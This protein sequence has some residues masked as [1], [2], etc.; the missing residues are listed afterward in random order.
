MLRLQHVPRVT[1]TL[2]CIGVLLFFVQSWAYF[3]MALGEVLVWLSILQR[4]GFS[5]NVRVKTNEYVGG[6]TKIPGNAEV[7]YFIP[8]PPKT[9]LTVLRDM[10]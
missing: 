4:A 3:S 5:S 8:Q 10:Y 7:F 9:A 6:D 1:Y 2:G